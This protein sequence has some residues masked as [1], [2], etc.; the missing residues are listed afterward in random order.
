MKTMQIFDITLRQI[1]AQRGAAVSFKERIE[2]A[3]TLDRLKVDAIELPPI[4]DQ[5]SDVLANKT[6]ASERWSAIGGSSM[7]S[8]A[9][10]CW[11][12]RPSPG[13]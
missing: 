2:I 1:A 4:A 13:W 12:T 11:P 9:P 8:S 10:T 3:R 5:R 6:I 7:A